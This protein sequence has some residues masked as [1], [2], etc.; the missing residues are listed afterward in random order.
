MTNDPGQPKYRLTFSGEVEK[1]VTVN[2]RFVRLVGTAGTLIQKKVS[3]VPE[4]KYA[5]KITEVKARDGKSIDLN[6]KKI[7]NDDVI[8]YS[9]TITNRENR[10]RKYYDMIRIKTDSAIRPEIII[11]LSGNIMEPRNKKNS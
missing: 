11:N 10:R 2:P 9:L 4:K 7:Q 5:F 3:I 8:G 1:I 6:L